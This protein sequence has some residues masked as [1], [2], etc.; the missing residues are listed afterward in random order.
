MQF[1]VVLP[2]WGYALA[3]GG[4][5]VLAWLAYARIATPL[6]AGTRA[7]LIGL[8][9]VTLVLLIATLL[10]PV[11]LVPPSAANNSLLPILV[12]VSRSMRL[13]DGDGPSRLARAQAIVR[14][15]Q[16]KLST[17]YRLE[18]LTFGDALAPGDV[19]QLTA[20]ARRSDLSGAIADL[21][22]RH[23]DHKLAGVIVI[24][25][26]GDTAAQEGESARSVSAPVIAVGQ[27]H[28]ARHV[29]QDR[30]QTVVRG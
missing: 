29:D 3:F 20:T 27:P 25:D 18:L 19:D 23:R 21:A 6:G 13:T 16:A 12:D 30:Q 15:L 14:D 1:A 2:W 26:G 17:E 28:A 24:S 4:A 7:L 10:R 5:I 9:A 22:D 8:R 11:M